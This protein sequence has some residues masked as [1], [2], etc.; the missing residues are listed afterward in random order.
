MAKKVIALFGKSGAGKDTLCDYLSLSF[1]NLNRVARITTRPK[2][3]N[4]IE[5]IS[6]LFRSEDLVRKRILHHGEQFLETGIFNNWIYT[7][8]I[9]QIK[10][11]WN[12]AAYDVDAVRQMIDNY[13]EVQVFPVYVQTSDKIRLLRALTRE[14]N[15]NVKEIVRRYQSDEKDYSSI[16]FDYISLDNTN[17]LDVENIYNQLLKNNIDL[18]N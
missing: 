13:Y 7:T 8:H 10:E 17:E 14:E 1:K 6:Y 18:R 9:D 12:I 16:D 4:E 11:G 2:R 5:G 3:E 15:P